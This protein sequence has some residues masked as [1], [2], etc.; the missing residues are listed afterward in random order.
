M[1]WLMQKQHLNSFGDGPNRCRLMVPMVSF[2]KPYSQSAFPLKRW[3]SRNYSQFHNQ[4]MKLTFFS[5]L[6][7]DGLLTDW[8]R[9]TS[10]VVD[11]VNAG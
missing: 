3:F 4:I 2:S 10:Y 7:L 6:M 1:K 5:K 8:F 9:Y 11:V